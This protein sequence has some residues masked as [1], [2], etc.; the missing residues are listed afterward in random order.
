MGMA[1]ALQGLGRVAESRAAL[2]ELEQKEGHGWAFQIAQVHAFAGRARPGVPLARPRHGA[3]GHGR[4]ARGE[5]RSPAAPRSGAI[6]ATPRSSPGWAFPRERDGP[7]HRGADPGPP[8][9]RRPSRRR[10]RGDPGV[11]P[12]GPPLPPLPPSRRGRRQRRVLGL[13]RERLARPGE[14]A[15]RGL[16]QG[17]GVPAGLERR[18]ESASNEAWRSRGR[19]FFC[20]E[21]SAL[22]EEIRTRSHLKVERQRQALDK[23]RESLDVEDVSLLALRIDQKLS[24]A[25]IAE[26]TRHRRGA[27]RAGG[28]HEA[29][30]AAEGT[31]RQDGEGPGALE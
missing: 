12:A 4:C 13:R 20:G 16:A 17:L 19:R 24:W 27:R 31:P 2:Q 29:L 1:L 14:L 10:D 26:V 28:A 25:E 30:R 15:G 8:G 22:A 21:A 6:P 11:R 3:A 23:L 18:H 5:G 7:E 9:G